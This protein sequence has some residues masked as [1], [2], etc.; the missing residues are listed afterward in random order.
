MGI[1]TLIRTWCPYVK[2]RLEEMG[3]AKPL[4]PR[5]VQPEG[6]AAGHRRSG[7]RRGLR[8]RTILLAGGIVLCL[9]G[10]FLHD[11]H[12]LWGALDKEIAASIILLLGL[13]ATMI[14]VAMVPWRRIDL[15]PGRIMLVASLLTILLAVYTFDPSQGYM[16][17]LNLFMDGNLWSLGILALGIGL[18]AFKIARDNLA[19][20]RPVVLA[21]LILCLVLCLAMGVLLG[22][23]IPRSLAIEKGLDYF[24]HLNDPVLIGAWFGLE[25]PSGSMKGFKMMNGRDPVIRP[26]WKVAIMHE[27][28]FGS[29]WLAPWSGEIIGVDGPE[30]WIR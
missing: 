11:P 16:P 6:I 7:W 15:N 20:R 27:A 24:S 21:G 2:R 9:A 25:R 26:V 8:T 18:L 4:L 17:R 28:S 5:E 13:A 29:V 10:G 1:G 22:S 3:D 30:K 12:L 23:R 14:A 19:R